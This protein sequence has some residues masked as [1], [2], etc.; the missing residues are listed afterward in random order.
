[1][2]LEIH[3]LLFVTEKPLTAEEITTHLS[4]ARSNV[5]NSLKELQQWGIVRTVHV[6]GDRRE[7]YDATKDVWE[8]F[9]SVV[10]EQKRREIDPVLR[11]LEKTV[12]ELEKDGKDGGHAKEQLSEMLDFFKV[13]NSW[14]EDMRGVPL[15][16]IKTF[17]KLGSK[18]IKTLGLLK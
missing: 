14:Y 17:L 9:R 16:I 18:A 5:S 2:D 1:M 8:M 10:N 4:V 11:M 13:M 15:P 12:A 3:A 6:M 7:H